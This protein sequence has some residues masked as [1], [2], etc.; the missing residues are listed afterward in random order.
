VCLA[1]ILSGWRLAIAAI[2]FGGLVTLVVYVVY[3][4]FYAADPEGPP[5]SVTGGGR[6]NTNVLLPTNPYET[7]RSV[8]QRIAEDVPDVACGQFTDEAAQ[9]FAT[10]FG[11][12]DCP[13]A[14]AQLNTQVDKSPGGKNAYAEPD[15]HGKMQEF[16]N[17]DVTTIQI[18]SCDL[19]VNAGP[20]L[21]LFTLSRIAA[22]Q[23]IITGHRTETC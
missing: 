15:F 14:V 5:A 1:R 13:A 21:G 18:S 2:I 19:G 12:A 22:N 11:A 10:D 20:R 7:V 6:T 3:Q 23:W 16:A 9:Q 17:P 8:Y 4:L